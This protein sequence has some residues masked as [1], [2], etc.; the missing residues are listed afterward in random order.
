MVVVAVVACYDLFLW[1]WL[2]LPGR[3]PKL[4]GTWRLQL[5]TR[6]AP[7]GVALSKQTCY[8][9][10]RQ[11]ASKLTARLLFEDGES[12]ATAAVLAR[13]HIGKK[14]LLFY[15]F[16]PKKPSPVDPRRKGAVSLDIAQRELN[17]RYWNDARAWGQLTSEGRTAKVYDTYRAASCPGISY[18]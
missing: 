7:E 4:H 13:D 2:P 15:D 9:S 5:E 3:P 1:R 18:R 12:R 8:L 11:T 17:G 16:E 10:I 6:E 14:L